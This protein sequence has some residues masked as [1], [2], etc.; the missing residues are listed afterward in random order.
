MARRLLSL[1]VIVA[2]AFPAAAQ[3]LA[4]LPA[5]SARGTAW[6]SNLI[7]PTLRTFTA[8]L[9]QLPGSSMDNPAIA[10]APSLAAFARVRFENAEEK[11]LARPLI[12]TL[13]ENSAAWVPLDHLERYSRFDRRRILVEFEALRAQ[14]G[15]KLE[16]QVLA[17]AQ[18]NDV[19]PAILGKNARL[20]ARLGEMYG[21][22]SFFEAARNIRELSASRFDGSK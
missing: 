9:R 8:S 10:A 7:L 14:T 11:I 3:D 19:D 16:P 17:V 4:S 6:A 20:L 18:I 1:A 12:R 22:A 5:F 13:S 21:N 15:A 2:C